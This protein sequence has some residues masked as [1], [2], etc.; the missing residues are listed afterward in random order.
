[1][2]APVERLEKDILTGVDAMNKKIRIN[3]AERPQNAKPPNRKCTSHLTRS[4]HS[5]SSL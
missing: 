2:Y 3:D 4:P 1:M 5:P